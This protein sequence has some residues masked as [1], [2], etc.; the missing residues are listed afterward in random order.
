MTMKAMTFNNR[1]GDDYFDRL[2]CF[3]DG[4]FNKKI[5][6][7]VQLRDT[8]FLVKTKKETYVV[9]AYS[10]N[11]KLTLQEAFTA[12]LR[13]EG[14]TKSYLYLDHSKQSPPIFEGKFFGCMEYL[15][16]SEKTFNYRSYKNQSEG[17]DLLKEFHMVTSSIV[18]RYSTLVPKIDIEEK[19]IERFDK[20]KKNIPVIRYF[21]KEPFINEMLDWANWSLSGMKEDQE[22]FL[23]EPHVILH[24][25]VAHHNFLRTS[26]G[27][28]KLIDFDLI[29][30]GPECIDLLQYANRILPHISWSYDFLGKHKQ[31]E[32]YLDKKTFLYALAFPAD[33][34]REWNRHL[35]EKSVSNPQNY[36]QVIELTLE[37]F[38]LRRQFVKKLK[39]RIKEL[40]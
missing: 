2:L 9:K 17:L 22:L 6:K 15:E 39:E 31:I 11:R 8:V 30:I 16:P 19:W 34:F 27:E 35:R 4:Q 37:Q 3:L 23:A 21:L 20:F 28:L 26:S 18:S 5:T 14:F 10:S 33:I 25:D 29:C 13:K 32:K 40:D 36:K 1:G 7:M 38:Y 24:G 12:T